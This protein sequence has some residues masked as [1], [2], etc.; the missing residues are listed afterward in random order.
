MCLERESP[1]ERNGGAM[2]WRA[3]AEGRMHGRSS[4]NITAGETAD[5]ERVRK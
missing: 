5:G 2:Q 4:G 3:H 1:N